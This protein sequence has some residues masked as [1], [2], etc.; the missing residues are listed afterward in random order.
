[1]PTAKLFVEDLKDSDDAARLEDAL[2][3]LGGVHGAVA[4]CADRCVEVDFEDDEVGMADIIEVAA[5]LG[6]RARLVS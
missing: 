2:R 1:V 4:S 6:L 5:G 3:G